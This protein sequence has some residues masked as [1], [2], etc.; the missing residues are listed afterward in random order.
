[1]KNLNTY[2]LSLQLEQLLLQEE[3]LR[4]LSSIV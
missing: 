3:T 1:M 4:D 2:N